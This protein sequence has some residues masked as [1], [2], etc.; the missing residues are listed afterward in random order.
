MNQTSEADGRSGADSASLVFRPMRADEARPIAARL[1]EMAPWSVLGATVAGL[2]SY[3]A[4]DDPCL[5]RIALERQGVL[6][7][8][9]TVRE[10]WLRGTYLELLA[11]LP[12]AQGQGIGAAVIAW[13]SARAV[14][15]RPN[16]WVTVSASNL[17]AQRFYRREGFE[18]IGP[19]EDLIKT[20]QTEILMRLRL[21]PAWPGS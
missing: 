8:L 20:G 19:L 17:D 21:E 14:P 12:E 15:T 10:R 16:L 2:E 4:S 6:L 3:L 7:G 18:P 11:V 13:L 9:V 5:E 1:V